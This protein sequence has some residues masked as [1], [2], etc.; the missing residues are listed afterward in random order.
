MDQETANAGGAHLGK[1]DLLTTR[2]N[3]SARP[4][5]NR[6]FLLMVPGCPPRLHLESALKS[7]P[8]WVLSVFKPL[9]PNLN[10]PLS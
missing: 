2:V 1:R 6:P 8:G 3:P 9:C 4:Q 10:L 7:F 5:S